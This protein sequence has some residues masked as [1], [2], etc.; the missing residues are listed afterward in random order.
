MSRNDCSGRIHKVPYPCPSTQN[1]TSQHAPLGRWQVSTVRNKK[2]LVFCDLPGSVAFFSLTAP[3]STNE[4]S[5][6]DTFLSSMCN[7]DII[8]LFIHP[9][10]PFILSVLLSLW[11]TL[12][13][14]NTSINPSCKPICPSHSPGN[15]GP[16]IKI[17]QHKSKWILNHLKM[18]E[19]IFKNPPASSALFP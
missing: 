6:T 7:I 15:T 1:V 2:I 8:H 17:S 12:I 4:M 9:L 16:R 13:N 18:P 10:Y 19:H 11:G 3:T 14:T 5:K